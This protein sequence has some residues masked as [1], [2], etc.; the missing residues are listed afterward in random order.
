MIGYLRSALE[1]ILNKSSPT[2]F[3]NCPRWLRMSM[4]PRRRAQQKTSRSVCEAFDTALQTFNASRRMFPRNAS[5][6]RRKI[7][8]LRHRLHVTQLP[9]T[10]RRI[11]HS[12]Q[13]DKRSYCQACNSAWTTYGSIL[14]FGIR[15]FFLYP[16]MRRDWKE[17]RQKCKSL[18][19]KPRSTFCLQSRITSM[20]SC[21]CSFLK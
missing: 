4:R 19:S 3:N 8:S 13:Q 14:W 21:S 6:H 1:T 20:R 17:Q 11:R 12:R 10:M 5:K 2:A 15:R 16:I 9:V 18:G 7:K